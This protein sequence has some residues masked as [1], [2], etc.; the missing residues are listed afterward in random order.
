MNAYTIAEALAGKF[1][2]L[3]PP[4]GLTAIRKS[5]SKLP[6]A[7][8][9]SP[10]VLVMLPSGAVT[11]GAGELNHSLQFH[12]LFHYAKNTGDVARDM[13]A[14][15]SWLGVLLTATFA[16]MD[17]SIAGIRKAYPTTYEQVVA[18]YA[19]DEFYGWDITWI[20]DFHETQVMVP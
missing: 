8:P 14:M 9:S 6:N 12:V 4:T 18:T 7:I 1:T 3:T 13:T 16:D 2:S 15:L 11:L 19:G 17:L 20:V 5:T 10:W